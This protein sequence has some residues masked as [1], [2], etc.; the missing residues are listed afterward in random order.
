MNCIMESWSGVT[1]H[2]PFNTSTAWA[3]VASG[4]K[5]S[6]Q[7]VTPLVTQLEGSLV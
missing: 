7:A 2:R 3:M 5:L 6:I 1:A 4:A